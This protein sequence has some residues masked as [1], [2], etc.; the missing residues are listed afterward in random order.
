MRSLLLELG[1]VH[2][3]FYFYGYGPQRDLHSFPTR[4]SSDLRL[5]PA[6]MAGLPRS[7]RKSNA[8]GFTRF[9][10]VLLRLFEN[11]APVVPPVHTVPFHVRLFATVTFVSV[12]PLRFTP[13]VVG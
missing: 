9:G 11:V 13:A 2:F 5:S 3:R 8:N 6:S 7:R 1:C 12:P 4:R 10:S